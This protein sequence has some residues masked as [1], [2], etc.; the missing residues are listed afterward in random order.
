MQVLRSII[1]LNKSTLAAH[2]VWRVIDESP[3]SG[4]KK[5]AAAHASA[6]PESAEGPGIHISNVEGS[7]CFHGVKFE[8]PGRKGMP[9]GHL[10]FLAIPAILNSWM[11]SLLPDEIFSGAIYQTLV[12]HA[13]MMSSESGNLSCLK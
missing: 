6:G 7:I 1:Q 10:F 4:G 2:E 9:V 13:V 11:A 5:T 12:S 8:Y 3:V